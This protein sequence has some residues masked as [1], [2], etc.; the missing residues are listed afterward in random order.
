MLEAG[1]ERTYDHG[2][3]IVHA[4]DSGHELHV[5]LEGSVNV[6]RAG[7]VV[8]ALAPGDLFG[9]VSILDGGPRTADVVAVGE[10]RCLSVP[11]E[12][13]R[14]VLEGEPQAAWALLGVLARRL[15]EG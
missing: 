2:D 4:G 7:R 15:R 6:E 1:E 14:S 8:R 11:R 9:E 10:T 3:V 12:V 13:V 5:V